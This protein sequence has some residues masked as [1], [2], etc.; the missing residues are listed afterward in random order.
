MINEFNTNIAFDDLISS[1][2]IEL[3]DR[4][5]EKLAKYITKVM[6]FLNN[7]GSFTKIKNFKG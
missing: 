5:R 4:M 2:E 3:T 1:C 7:S 6:S